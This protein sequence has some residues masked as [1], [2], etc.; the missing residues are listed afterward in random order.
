MAILASDYLRHCRL[1]CSNRRTVS[2][3]ILQEVL[4][5]NTKLVFWGHHRLHNS[6]L[7]G[8]DICE[9]ARHVRL[10]AGPL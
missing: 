1:F 6:C 3:E 4:N 7:I 5:D 2:D 9:T 10:K 8:R